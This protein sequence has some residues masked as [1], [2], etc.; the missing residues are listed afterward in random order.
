MARLALADLP[1]IA[2]PMAGGPTTPELVTAAA[3]AGSLGFLAGGYLSA[4]RLA[5]DIRA[6]R[7]LLDGDQLGVNLFVPDPAPVDRTAVL[8]Y[9]AMLQ[10]EAE[11][12]GFELPEPRWTDDDDWAAKL[13]L[14]V[15]DPVPWLSFTFGLPNGDEAERLRQAGTRLLATVTSVDE[16]RHAASLGVEGLIVQASAAGGHRATFDPQRPAGGEPLPL[17]VGDVVA[18]T[19][20][21]VVAAGGVAGPADVAEALAAGAEA[22]QVGTALLLADEAGTRPVHRRV[23]TDPLR[24]TAVMRAFTGRLARGLVNEFSKKYD[25]WAPSAYPTLHHLTAP[26]RRWAAENDD[27]ERLHLWAGT[28]HH[29]AKTGPAADLIHSLIP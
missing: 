27:P 26:M 10:E 8:G 18:A 29:A 13:D 19:G 9:R 25:G 3:R 12:H 21:P 23:L 11:R 20:L 7:K 28:G 4:E 17:L 5:D 15:A 22:V 2:A 1:V 16:A 14:L 6:T 24:R